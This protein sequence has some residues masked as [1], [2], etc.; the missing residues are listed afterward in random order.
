MIVVIAGKEHMWLKE[1]AS[2]V[3]VPYATLY[4]WLERHP[5]FS[6]VRI[7]KLIFVGLEDVLQYKNSRG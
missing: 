1:A 7:G 2:K 6:R 3:G 5:E 4:S